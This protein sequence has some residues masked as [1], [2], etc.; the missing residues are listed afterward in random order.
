[1]QIRSKFTFAVIA[2]VLS[3]GSGASD[4]SKLTN[5]QLLDLQ[6]GQMTEQQLKAFRNEVRSRIPDMGWAE[7]QQFRDLM[8]RHLKADPEQD[9]D[10]GDPGRSQYRES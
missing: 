4:F 7:R 10:A 2:L 1:M 6:P 5:E 8:R 9:S 3:T